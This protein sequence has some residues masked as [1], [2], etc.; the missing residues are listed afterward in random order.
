MYDG[1]KRGSEC[2]VVKQARSWAGMRCRGNREGL[3]ARMSSWGME[4]DCGPSRVRDSMR[5]RFYL[6]LLTSER[7]MGSL[8]MIKN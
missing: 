3:P 5:L 4:R 6:K 7:A 8:K 2:E 1:A